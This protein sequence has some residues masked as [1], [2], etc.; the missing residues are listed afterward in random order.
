M[1]YKLFIDESGD[2][3]LSNLNPDFPIFLLC[4]IVI[5]SEEYERIR[6]GFNEIKQGFWKS[7]HVIFHS[8][9]IRKCETEFKYLF[10]L[11]LKA[12]FYKMLDHVI[13]NSDYK[14]IAS[15]IQ[16]EKYI[17]LYGRLSDDVY[18]ISLSFIIERAIFYLDD[19][20]EDDISLEIII[21]KRGFKED[22]KLQEHFQRILSRGTGYLQ[23]DRLG[24]YHLTI[25]FKDKKENINGLQLADLIAYPIARYILEPDRIN[26]S[27]EV[28]KDKF[29][30]RLGKRYGLKIFP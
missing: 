26:P 2:H 16:K 27:F 13:S 30:R 7:E 11:D 28:F 14:I 22:K 5:S 18:E 15:A 23:S 24:K 21:E 10:D 19:L 9:D 1:K 8:R 20:K 6:I 4:G 12:R 25:S 3:G 17:K 29:Y